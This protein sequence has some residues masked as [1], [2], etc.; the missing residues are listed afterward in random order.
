MILIS[1]QHLMIMRVQLLKI[2]AQFPLEKSDLARWD[3]S[4]SMQPPHWCREGLPRVLTHPV[5]GLWLTL[6]APSGMCA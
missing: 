3:S 5:P 1:C 4:P 6:L 2:D